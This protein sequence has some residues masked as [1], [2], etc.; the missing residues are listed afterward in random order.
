M[1]SPVMFMTLPRSSARSQL[2]AEV[3]APSY[4]VSGSSTPGPWM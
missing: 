3:P 2:Q 4:E 1:G